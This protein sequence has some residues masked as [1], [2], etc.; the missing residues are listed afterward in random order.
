MAG[1]VPITLAVEDDLSEH[2]LRTLLI[3]TKRNFIVGTVY[4]KKGSGFLK[5]KLAAFNNAAKGSAHLLLTD[6]DNVYCVPTLIEDWFGCRLQEFA[7]RRH[8]NLL[9]RVAV[10]EVEA[11]VMADREQFAD[12]LGVSRH[13]I[14]DQT[15]TIP[16]PKSLLLQLASKSRKRDL[17][18]DIVPRPG[19]K[20]K[21][22]P[23]YNGRLGAF[24]LS[25]WRANVASAHSLSLERTWKKLV[26]FHPVHK[27]PEVI[28]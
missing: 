6:L 27:A 3:Q 26:A 2:L 9:F 1:E 8:V 17:R 22:G 12:F 19:D 24:V 13:L 14:P 23:D 11:W 21:I 4:G 16:D 15:D 25:S 7:T 18:N 10:R 5:Q 20:R 28:L